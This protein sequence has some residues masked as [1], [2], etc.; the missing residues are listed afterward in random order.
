[1]RRLLLLLPVLAAACGGADPAGSLPT[2]PVLDTSTMEPLVAETLSAARAAVVDEP[3]NGRRWS[4]LGLAL[5]AHFFL[6]EAEACLAVA[7]ELDPTLFDATYDHAVLGTMLEREVDEVVAR[8]VSAAALR[9]DYPPVHARLGDFLLASGDA[10]S[11]LNAFERAREVS[12]GLDYEY[13][14]AQLG[15]GRALLDQGQVAPAVERLAPL[16]ARFPGD[17]AVATALAQGLTM[18][19]RVDEAA[20]VTARQSAADSGKVQ[21]GD[22]VRRDIMTR[23]RSAAMNFQR[24]EAMVKRREFAAAAVEFQRV[25]TVDEGNRTARLYLASALMEL[26]RIPEARAELTAVLETS[27]TDLDAHRM[28][29]LL[30]AESGAFEEADRHFKVVIRTAPLDDLAYQAWVTA[31]GSMNRWD[32]ALFRIEGWRAASPS[33]P[34]PAFLQAMALFNAGRRDEA[35][36]ALDAAKA[37]APGHPMQAQAERILSR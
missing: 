30:D 6:E 31:L 25:L 35:V 34:E 7:I 36:E 19:R 32:E 20:A 33:R 22:R 37:L 28:L 18:L 9:D 4:D 11:S 29:G 15:I 23:S 16:H 27:S 24:G 26:R 13:D 10:A 12:A 17:P 8:F 3:A 21:L 1:M 2:P 14:Y 5:D